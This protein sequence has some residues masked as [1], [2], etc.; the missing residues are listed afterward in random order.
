M[1]SIVS[2][3]QRTKATLPVQDVAKMEQKPFGKDRMV[4]MTKVCAHFVCPDRVEFG[5]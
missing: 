1:V 5:D 2:L 3:E 4:K